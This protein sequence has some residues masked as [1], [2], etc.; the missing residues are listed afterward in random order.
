MTNGQKTIIVVEDE[1]DAAEMFAEMMRVNGFRVLKAT[2]S[3][4]AMGM[5]DRGETCGCHPGYYDAGYL[6]SGSAAVYATASQAWP[7]S[8]SSWYQPKACQP[9]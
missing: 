3:K 2:G 1:Q 4:P 5:I 8:R 7:V 6:W 9:I